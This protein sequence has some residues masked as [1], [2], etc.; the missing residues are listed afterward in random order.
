MR[1]IA[2]ITT[3]ASALLLS[4]C[5]HKGPNPDDPYEAINRKIYRFNNAFDAT[6]LKPPARLYKAVLP[7]PVRASINN[8]YNN[9][10]MIPTVANDVLQ[11]E[12]RYAI[13]D[14]WRF[15]INSTFGVAGLFDVADKRFGLPPHSND[16]GLTFAKW[17]DKKS[18][19]IMIP[20]MGPSTIR[21]GMGMLFEY[22]VITPY[23]YIGNDAVIY[24]LIGLRYV[25]LRSQLFETE[26]L[27]SEALDPYAF[28]RDAYLQHRHY[29]ITGQQGGA[30]ATNGNDNNDGS[31]YVDDDDS[32]D[33]L[34]A[35][36]VDD[37][38]AKG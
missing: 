5:F 29:R 23:P 20:L 6:I 16:L 9:I 19:F 13:K 30:L 1:L 36:Y 8:A 4:G 28:L 34:G 10:N 15:V 27:M 3:L 37:D 32:V 21:D 31:D 22:T 25:D 7:D 33:D 35:D 14:T 12:W 26:R 38:E 11:W 2:S 24:G 18:P 17:G